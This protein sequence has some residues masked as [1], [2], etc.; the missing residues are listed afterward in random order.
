MLRVH[1][2]VF[3]DLTFWATI[4]LL[5]W[6]FHL[7]RWCN[8]IIKLWFV[9]SC[10]LWSQQTSCTETS[11][12]SLSFHCQS[13]CFFNTH[14]RSVHF[15]NEAPTWTLPS[16]VE[17]FE[18]TDIDTDTESLVISGNTFQTQPFTDRVEK[19]TAAPCN[20]G[21]IVLQTSLSYIFDTVPQAKHRSWHYH[22]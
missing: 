3:N 13:N 11:D 10:R 5:Q 14:L 2:P 1:S 21:R 12:V 6:R 16:H 4:E 15:I 9:L 22:R 17:N 19:Q 20:A 18:S 7:M 8:W